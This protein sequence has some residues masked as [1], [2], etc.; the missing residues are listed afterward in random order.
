MMRRLSLGLLILLSTAAP[1]QAGEKFA[2]VTTTPDLADIARTIIGEAGTVYA[3]ARPD[4]DPH[5]VQAKPSHMV[6][7]RK[8]DAVVYNG[9]ELEIGWLPKL[10]EGARNPSVMPGRPG[11]LD[12]SRAIDHLL[13]VPGGEVDR[14]MGDIHPEGNPH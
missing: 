14:S 12:A 3:I 11:N 4:Q 5:Y 9:L 6:K 2:V 7:I 13:E 10:L 1:L 8:A